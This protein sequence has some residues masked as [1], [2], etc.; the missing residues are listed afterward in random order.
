MWPFILAINTYYSPNREQL[1]WACEINKGYELQNALINRGWVNLYKRLD[2]SNPGQDQSKV[3]RGC[4]TFSLTPDLQLELTNQCVSSR[5][6][7]IKGD[8][9]DC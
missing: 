9:D 7:E 6:L 4:S 5:T 2:E 3:R 8:P 1:L